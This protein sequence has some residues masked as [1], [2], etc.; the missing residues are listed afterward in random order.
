MDLRSPAP[1][2]CLSA[3]RTFH[4]VSRLR[5]DE[6]AEYDPQC[7][8]RKRVE[9]TTLYA[10]VIGPMKQN[11]SGWHYLCGLAMV[12]A[13]LT[14]CSNEQSEQK[15]MGSMFG[16][17]GTKTAQPATTVA[18][19]VKA[20]LQRQAAVPAQFP[21]PAV[22]AFAQWQLAQLRG[23]PSDAQWE[24]EAITGETRDAFLIPA[25][26]GQPA[27][28]V[29][30]SADEKQS[31]QVWELSNDK[32]ARFVKQRPVALDP[33]QAS[34]FGAYPLAVSCLPGQQA[35]MAVGYHDPR[36][37]QALFIYDTA[38]NQFRRIDLIAPDYSTG[39]PFVFFETLVATPEAMLVAYHTDLI[40]LSAG[41]YVY[42][43][44]HVLLFSARHPQGL[45]ALK[46]D[47]DDDNV[48][49][50]AMQGNTLWLQTA[51]KRK[52]AWDFTW[53]LDLGHVL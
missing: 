52:K 42:Q 51:D 14:A 38:S 44:D 37:Q 33:A 15:G 16:F 7:N 35:V 47:I 53:S 5:K 8:V 6:I 34:W 2:L 41:S 4:F 13:E 49:A 3:W 46:L 50:W 30:A 19:Q 39:P 1:G 22:P 45:E 17:F 27:L 29:L 48:R 21:P 23:D 40:R 20:T 28:A 26:A 18:A 9:T 24:P 25:T 11:S 36:P 32:P 31:A 10:K 12:C 43:Y